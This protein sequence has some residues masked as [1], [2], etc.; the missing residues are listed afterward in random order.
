MQH[1]YLGTL[2]DVV[3]VENGGGAFAAVGWII[4]DGLLTSIWIGLG[5]IT[6]MSR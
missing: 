2:F 3:G 1:V 6:V 5:Q 4:I